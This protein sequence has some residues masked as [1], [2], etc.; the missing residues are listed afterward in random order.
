[1]ATKLTVAAGTVEVIKITT[2]A[3]AW[4]LLY[5]QFMDTRFQSSN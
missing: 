4:I 5:P 3:V 2:A 1:L